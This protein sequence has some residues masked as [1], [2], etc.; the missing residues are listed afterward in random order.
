MDALYFAVSSERQTTENQFEDL[1]R[2]AERDNSG[3]AW[4]EAGRLL[5]E[6]LRGEQLPNRN[7]GTRTV[8][9]VRPELVQEL[10][11]RCIYVDQGRSGKRGRRRPSVLADEARRGQ[12]ET[13]LAFLRA[14]AGGP[15]WIEDPIFTAPGAFRNDHA[16]L[17]PREVQVLGLA[18]QGLT[19]GELA[20][21][22]EVRPG[23]VKV[24]FDHL[25]EKTGIDSRYR[26]ALWALK[27][28][29]LVVVK[30]VG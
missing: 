27:Q 26:L 3:R 16:T 20:R 2:V 1:L 12:P 23:T 25:Y 28:R 18:E 15:T 9:R 14:A 17:T 13:L 8:Y 7:G 19:T 10:T 6:C 30:T 29:A 5:S 22:L 24:H 11:R 21:E 4:S